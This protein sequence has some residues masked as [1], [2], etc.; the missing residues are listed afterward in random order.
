MTDVVTLGELL[1]DMVATRKN[2]T[3][4]DAPAF[5]P[6]AGGAPANVAVGVQRLGK[7]AAF[8]GKV[9]RDDFGRGLRRTLEAERVDTHN[10]IEDASLLT[11]L[12]FVS[13][14]DRGDPAFAFFQG[15]HTN[16]KPSELDA[17]LIQGARVFHCGSVSL[18]NEPSRSATLEALRIAKAAGVIC[19]YDI[20]WRPALWPDRDPSIAKAPLAEV[21]IIK[22]NEGELQLVT[23]EA[24]VRTGLSKLD[25]PAILI[26]I[27]LG[28]K[29]CMYR[30]EGQ[31]YTQSVPPVTNVV[32]A[33]GAGDS[34]M[35]AILADFRLP[36][37]VA[38]LA[39]LTR[40][41]CQAGAITTTRRGAIPSLPRVAELDPL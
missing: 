34:F 11:T 33:T 21:D 19:S 39:R 38:Y 29:G 5:E 6:K 18:V 1:I 26:V 30:F 2:V 9:G 24:D 17:A 40:R 10:L 20:N 4:F 7:S 3:L 22:M 15:A 28:E 27:T 41:A 35:A 23:G 32:D 14:S 25:V 13:L 16:L 36:L 8:I 37:D 31:I 12:A